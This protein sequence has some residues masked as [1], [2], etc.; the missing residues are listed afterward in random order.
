MDSNSTSNPQKE[1]KKK[2]TL[3]NILLEKFKNT[4]FMFLL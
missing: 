2:D 4:F 1:G 3:L